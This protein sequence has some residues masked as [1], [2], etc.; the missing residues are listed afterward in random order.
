MTSF[1]TPTTFTAGQ[2]LTAAS[3]NQQ[4]RDN[5]LHVTEVQNWT[6]TLT[7]SGT[8]TK[9][10]SRARYWAA[11]KRVHAECLLAVTGSGTGANAILIGVP[12]NFAAATPTFT[13]VGSGYVHD[14]S[15]GVTYTGV[16]LAN[17]TSTVQIRVSGTGAG[18]GGAAAP[19]NLALASGDLVSICIDYESS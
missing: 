16:V 4:I 7:Q 6:P 9:T 19:H 10:V 1:S 8:V 15:G 2:T 17:T 14:N 13:C 5:M 12:V 11:D 18:L 3:L